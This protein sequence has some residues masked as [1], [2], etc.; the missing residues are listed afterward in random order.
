M[1]RKRFNVIAALSCQLFHGHSAVTDDT[2]LEV[3][4][5]LESRPELVGPGPDVG[6]SKVTVSHSVSDVL[7]STFGLTLASTWSS[8][9]LLTSSSLD[10]KSCESKMA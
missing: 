8:S 3:V 2:K 7:N 9:E 1:V 5:G 10:G 4:D 6:T